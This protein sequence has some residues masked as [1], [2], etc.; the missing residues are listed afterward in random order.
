M[1]SKSTTSKNRRRGHNEGSI[2]RRKDGRWVA[3]LTV[4]GLKRRSYYG[5]TRAEVQAKLIGA[6]AALSGGLV[7]QANE[8]LTV[9]QFLTDWL[10]DTAKPWVRPSTFKGYEGKIRTHVLPALGTV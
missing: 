4:G 8:R 6:A 2:Y 10:S 5:R 3:V 1:A 9:G 7:P